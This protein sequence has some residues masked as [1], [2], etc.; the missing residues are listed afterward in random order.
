MPMSA[1]SAS[2]GHSI[3]ILASPCVDVA[4]ITQEGNMNRLREHLSDCG[5]LWFLIV[6]TTPVLAW[7]A[8]MI[9]S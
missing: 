8:W 4:R 5:P 7:M 3:S 1:R 6:G 9:W 2:V